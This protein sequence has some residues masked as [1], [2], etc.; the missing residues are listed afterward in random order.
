MTWHSNKQFITI[1]WINWNFV[2]ESKPIHMGSLKL[3]LIRQTAREPSIHTKQSPTDILSCR[4]LSP[5]STELP[6]FGWK[7]VLISL[8]PSQ[9]ELS[10]HQHRDV[11]GFLSFCYFI[12]HFL[13]YFLYL[14]FL[15][16]RAGILQSLLSQFSLQVT[17]LFF[18]GAFI[19]LFTLQFRVLN[20]HHY[21]LSTT[22][23]ILN[24]WYRL[25][26]IFV[27]LSL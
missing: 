5:Q 10:R 24:T 2:N 7:L 14:H 3:R 27:F 1:K 22:L 9:S 8:V 21:A 18:N 4:P 11:R 26:N 12:T 23:R 6:C 17:H 15:H 16:S 13:L 19:L 20:N 25:L